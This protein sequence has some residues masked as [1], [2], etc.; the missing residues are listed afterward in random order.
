M[1]YIRKKKIKGHTYYYAVEGRYDDKGRVKQKV[2][3]YLGNIENMAL[4]ILSDPRAPPITKITG[5]FPIFS[6]GLTSVI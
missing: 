2:I 1:A 3:K 6:F 5:G 4:L